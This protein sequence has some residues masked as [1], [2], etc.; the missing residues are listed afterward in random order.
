VTDIEEQPAFR[1]G[2]GFRSWVR[3]TS[4][5]VRANLVGGVML[6]GGAEDVDDAWR[7]FLARA[8][9]GD[10]VVLRATPDEGYDEW[11]RE[12]AP[13]R[14][15]QT[16]QLRDPAAAED[17]FVIGSIEAAD[18]LFIAGGDQSDYVRVWTGT[19]IQWAVNAA[20]ATGV[21][22]GGISAGLAVLGEISFTAERD[23]VTSEEALADP[24]DDRVRLARGLL[25]VPGLETTITDSHFSER[26]RLGRLLVFMAR[27]LVA[28]WADEVRSIG[29]DEETAALLEPD[30]T[31]TITGEGDAWFLRMKTDDVV[32]CKPGRPLSTEPIEAVVAGAA[33]NF[34]LSSWSGDGDVRSVEAG[35]GS[36]R[37]DAG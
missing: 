7:W 19:P 5:T 10:I 31:A 21:P 37:I 32:S 9:Y 24:F 25:T 33:A 11:L 23:T 6:E 26:S 20:I 16:L 15:F 4:A 28:G 22:V 12:L 1:E 8:G 14:S 30:G 17:P 3:G 34:D 18:G 2:H 35:D 29:I 36:V 13:L 27:A